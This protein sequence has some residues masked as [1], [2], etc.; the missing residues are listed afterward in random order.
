MNA[1]NASAACGRLEQ[2]VGVYWPRLYP[3]LAM[4]VALLAPREFPR[5]PRLA[6][7][8][9]DELAATPNSA[10]Q[11]VRSFSGLPRD[12]LCRNCHLGR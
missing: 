9:R 12:E 3:N 4:A 1:Q 8:A 10:L 6:A 7:S 5:A 2:L 11:A